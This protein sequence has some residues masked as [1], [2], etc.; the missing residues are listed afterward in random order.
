VVFDSNELPQIFKGFRV[1]KYEEATTTSDF[2]RFE[3]KVVRL[4][5]VK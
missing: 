1:V 3:T 2:G 4:A 5:A